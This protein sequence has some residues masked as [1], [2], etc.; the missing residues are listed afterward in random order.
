MTNFLNSCGAVWCQ[1]M[2]RGAMWPMHGVYRCRECMR[3]YE[4]PWTVKQAKRFVIDRKG[5]RLAA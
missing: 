3:L 5:G 4:V 1:L 2:H